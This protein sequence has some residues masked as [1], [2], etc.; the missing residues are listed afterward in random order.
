MIINCYRRQKKIEDAER[1]FIKLQ[2]TSISEYQ[3]ILI[4]IQINLAKG[5]F[6]EAIKILEDSETQYKNNQEFLELYST[7][8]RKIGSIKKSIDKIEE[9]KSLGNKNYASIV[10]SLRL[11]ENSYKLGFKNLI[12]AS[13]MDFFEN[14]LNSKGIKIWQG[15]SLNNSKLIVYPGKGIALGDKIFFF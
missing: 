10:Y 15:E 8:L 12:R 2:S 14:F 11:A 4:E 7:A 9:S 3:K 5:E 6:Y 13:K 1:E